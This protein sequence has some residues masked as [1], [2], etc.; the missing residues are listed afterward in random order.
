MRDLT[1][2]QFRRAL[3]RNGFRPVPYM[4]GYVDVGDG[5]HI[6]APNAGPRRRSQI[7][8]LIAERNRRAQ[9]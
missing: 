3:E 7:A 6:Y 4:G 2:E 5:L 1:R 9:R 8:Y